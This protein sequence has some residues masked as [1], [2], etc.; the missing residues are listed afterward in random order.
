MSQPDCMMNK[1]IVETFDEAFPK[2][3]VFS[4]NEELFTSKVVHVKDNNINYE[5]NT[6][7]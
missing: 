1:Q 5:G 4:N 7:G 6:S 2:K 3:C